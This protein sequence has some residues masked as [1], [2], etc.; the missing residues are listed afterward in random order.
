MGASVWRV[1][2]SIIYRTNSRQ[3][4]DVGLYRRSMHH[5]S[6]V[7]KWI[8][9]RVRFLIYFHHCQFNVASNNT[10]SDHAEVTILTRYSHIY[11]TILF[12]WLLVDLP[13]VPI[14][15]DASIRCPSIQVVCNDIRI[16]RNDRWSSKANESF[17][18]FRRQ[19][20]LK[21]ITF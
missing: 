12:M 14:R 4:A 13:N 17:C 20:L 9:E 1:G 16:Q 10:A 2:A 21:L 19:H 18:H 7:R 6:N 5:N 15:L 8:V 3:S 11:S